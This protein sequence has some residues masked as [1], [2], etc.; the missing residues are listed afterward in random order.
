MN[1][2]SRE[3]YILDKLNPSQDS[4]K[5]KFIEYIIEYHDAVYG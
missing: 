2:Q 1:L 3:N 4:S 5:V